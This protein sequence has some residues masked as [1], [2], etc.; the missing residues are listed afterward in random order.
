MLTHTPF[1]HEMFSPDALC[2]Q[3]P[4]PRSS[5][6]AAHRA[7]ASSA[8]VIACGWCSHMEK[9]RGASVQTL[10]TVLTL[11]APADGVHRALLGAVV[12]QTP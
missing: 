1:F 11:H 8:Y 7:R 10:R 6:G 3:P 5:L 9:G 4:P 2:P 12:P